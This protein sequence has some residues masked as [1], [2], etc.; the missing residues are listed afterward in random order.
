MKLLF[1]YKLEMYCI[2][3]IVL[4][5]LYLLIKYLFINRHEI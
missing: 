1:D 4:L 3:L 5:L 2:Y